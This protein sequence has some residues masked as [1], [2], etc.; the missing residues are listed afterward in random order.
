MPNKKVV[1]LAAPI[2]APWSSFGECVDYIKKISPKVA[3]PVHDGLL[4]EDTPGPTYRLPPQILE[5]LGILFEVLE[6]GVETDFSQCCA[7]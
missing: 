3:I 1:I 4:K 2:V 5:P 7:A 6:P